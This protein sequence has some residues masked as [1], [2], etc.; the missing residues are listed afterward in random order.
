MGHLAE[1]RV[2]V[3]F[4]YTGEIKDIK[5]NQESEIIDRESLIVNHQKSKC[6]ETDIEEN[7]DTTFHVCCILRTTKRQCN[8]NKGNGL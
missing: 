8:G 1:M 2:E 4:D 3:W 5:V 7:C 6:Q